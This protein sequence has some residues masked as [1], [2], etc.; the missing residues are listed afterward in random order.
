MAIS[1]IDGRH[2]TLSGV[3]VNHTREEVY[4][5]AKPHVEVLD[6]LIK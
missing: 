5:E 4:R 6:E 3:K 1:L 2:D